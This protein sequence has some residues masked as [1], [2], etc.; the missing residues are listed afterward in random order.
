MTK[1]KQE[2]L[3]VARRVLVYRL[4]SLGD[5]IVALPA[6][7]LV[8]QA[9]ANAELSLLANKP[10]ASKA[11]AMES[12]LG[13]DFFREVID[14][15]V[16]LRDPGRLLAVAR[17]INAGKFDV[18]VNLSAGRGRFKAWR[19]FWFFRLCGIRSIIGTPARKEDFEVMTEEG[20]EFYES[21]TRRLLR[22]VSG[23]GAASLD[24]QANWDLGLT[25]AER[26]AARDHLPICEQPTIAACFGTKMQS[27]DWGADNWQQLITQLGTTLKGWRLVVVGSADET[28]LAACCAAGWQGPIVNLC[29]K[30]TPRESAAVLETAE[31]FIG[32]DSGPMHLASA[33]GTPCVAVFSARGLPG[34][35]FPA[36]AGHRMIYHKTDCFGCGLEVCIKE[37]KRCILSITVDEVFEAV[38]ESLRSRGLIG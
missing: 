28:E 11:A 19:D 10:V 20:G 35:W 31:L 37:K 34:Q 36:R 4:G 14:Y 23:L 16:G 6:L 32:H 13:P 21:E 27:K 17:K 29:G 18:L 3:P 22:R 25:L 2:G 1:T 7:M 8:K 38:M 5:T 30:L 15:P 26:Q 9:F 12:V 33:V 24:D